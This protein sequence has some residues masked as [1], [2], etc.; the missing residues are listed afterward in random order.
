MLLAR[1]I[2]SHI[3]NKFFYGEES[4]CGEGEKEAKGNEKALYL[5]KML[6]NAIQEENVWTECHTNLQIKKSTISPENDNN[7]VVRPSDIDNIN[8]KQNNEVSGH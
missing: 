3:L 2:L 6:V 5:G 1:Q 4:G 8:L 7:A